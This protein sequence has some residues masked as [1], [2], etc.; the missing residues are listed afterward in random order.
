MYQSANQPR[1]PLQASGEILGISID[2]ETT[3]R[4]PSVWV[5]LEAEAPSSE[6]TSKL[7]LTLSFDGSAVESTISGAIFLQGRLARAYT[8]C[9]LGQSGVTNFNKFTEPEKDLTYR[10]LREASGETSTAELLLAEQAAGM[11]FTRIAFEKSFPAADAETDR[12]VWINCVMTSDEL[13]ANGGGAYWD[14]ETPIVGLVAD[15]PPA[16]PNGVASSGSYFS[17][18]L[19]V[20]RGDHLFYQEG[21]PAP[22]SR[23][24]SSDSFTESSSGR[25]TT[26]E[27][28][29]SVTDPINARYSDTVAESQGSTTVFFAGVLAGLF[30]SFIGA[31]LISLIDEGL[32]FRVLAQVDP[33]PASVTPPAEPT[34]QPPPVGGSRRRFLLFRRGGSDASP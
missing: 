1:P 7:A 5:E 28:T 22:S 8:A 4:V 24:Q 23:D 17:S 16:S 11:E 3:T 12:N 19:S 18:T 31:G 6:T 25:T 32:R 14:V 9:D 27:T 2:G 20:N 29:I 21:Y 26:S 33:P 34:P 30:A 15:A 10:L 13:W